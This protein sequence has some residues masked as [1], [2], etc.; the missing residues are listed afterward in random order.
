MKSLC[1]VE[2]TSL[3]SLKSDANI[4]WYIKTTFNDVFHVSKRVSEMLTF[5][6]RRTHSPKLAFCPNQNKCCLTSAND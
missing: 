5:S 4:N 3:L 6:L 2:E 1:G